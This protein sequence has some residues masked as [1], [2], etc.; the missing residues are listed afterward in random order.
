MNNIINKQLKKDDIIRYKNKTWKVISL[1][2]D[3]KNPI[4]STIHL[5]NL[6]PLDNTKEIMANRWTDHIKDY[7]I[8]TA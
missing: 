2:N 1:Y 8:I 7:E 4:Y 3:N 6:D 5:V